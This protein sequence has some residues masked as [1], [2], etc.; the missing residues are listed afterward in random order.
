MN[1]AAIS[2]LC[3]NHQLALF[4]AF[5][6]EIGETV[7]LLGPLEPGFWP[8]F[9]S[10]PEA[11][12]GNRDTLDRWSKRVISAIAAECG[13]EAVFPFGGPPYQPF[14]RWAI[15]SGRAWQSPAGPLVHDTAG[16]MISYRGALVLPHRIQLPETAHNPCETCADKP[17][18]SACPVNALS[19]ETGYQLARCHDFLDTTQGAQCMSLGCAARRAC[20][21]SQQYGRLPEQSA[22]HMKA[23]HP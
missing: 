6:N 12:D 3:A 5:H 10:S 23:F 2:K 9:R 18:L 11:Q 20:P 7:V 4:G 21:I 16:M 1:Y 13:A 19:A 17:C 8:H 14:I 15:Q 22:F